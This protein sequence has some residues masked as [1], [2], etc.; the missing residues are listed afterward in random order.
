ML[1][2][3]A[4]SRP[5]DTRITLVSPH[6]ALTYSGMVPGVVAGH[7]AVGDCTIPLE[8]LL[9]RAGGAFVVAPATGLDAA[10]R[11]VRWVDA[12]GATRS[13]RYDLLSID[14]GGVIEPG[15]IPGAGRHAF[16]VR[17]IE[18]F[19]AALC[20]RLEAAPRR[21]SGAAVIGGGAAGF[22]LAL[23]LRHRL[24]PMVPVHLVTGGPPVLATHAPGVRRRAGR[25]LRR[26]GVVVHESMCIEV[27]AREVVLSS[28]A[29][30]DSDLSVVAIGTRAPGWLKGSGLALD[31][32]GFV[33]TRDTLQSVSHPSVYAAG[34][35]AARV[36]AAR[37]RSG[38]YAV[39]AGPPLAHNLR[40]ALEGGAPA[41]YR[42]QRRA[43]NLLACGERYAI[44]SWGDWSW[45]GR[46]MWWLKDRI[47][48]RF[49][50]VSRAA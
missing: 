3:F 1:R 14:V 42:P 23:A 13:L 18:A 36:D 50:A 24:G 17:P 26:R 8:P 45:E 29:H 34:D 30:I 48:R 39:R 6:R 44:A 31:A 38:V 22:E 7:Y 35:V 33:A 49:V 20:A 15:T 46:A 2:A 28:G 10:G 11:C 16:P 21:P 27:A 41:R 9:Q 5:P 25:A 4:A 37:P 12:V 43:L 47:D 40:C 19:V 32:D